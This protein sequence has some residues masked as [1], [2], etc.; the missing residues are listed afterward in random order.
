MT[1]KI[2]QVCHLARSQ[3]KIIYDIKFVCCCSQ[4]AGRSSCSIISRDISTVIPFAHTFAFQFGLANV[5]ICGKTPKTRAKT[6]CS[7]DG[8]RCGRCSV[9][10]YTYTAVDCEQNGDTSK[11]WIFTGPTASQSTCHSDDNHRADI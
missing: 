2:H 4:S 7:V 1:Y 6:E 10:D 11:H 5:F 8:H 9:Y 3:Q